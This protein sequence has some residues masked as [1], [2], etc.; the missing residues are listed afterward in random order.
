MH[1][2]DYDRPDQVMFLCLPCHLRIH[3]FLRWTRIDW[4]K[5]H[6]GLAEE[7]VRRLMIKGHKPGERSQIDVIFRIQRVAEAR[8]GGYDRETI[9]AV[10][11]LAVG[12]PD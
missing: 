7:A 2:P 12:E 6:T 5:C 9:F 11:P 8:D 3:A 1:H 10:G 4:W